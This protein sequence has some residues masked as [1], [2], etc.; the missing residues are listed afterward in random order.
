MTLTAETDQTRTDPTRT[1]HTMTQTHDRTHDVP[2]ATRPAAARPP[3]GLNL[4]YLRLELWRI[5]RDPVAMFFTAILP[6]F[7]Y[8][9]FGAA[10]GWSGEDAGNGNVAMYVMISMAAYGA[11]TATVGVGGFSAV[12]RMQGWG[13]Q[14][15]LTPMSDAQYVAIKAL[16]SLVI[17][18]VPITLIYALG[19]V[20]GAEAR[21][22]AWLGSAA[23]V[24]VGAVMF[25]LYGLIFGLAFRSESAVGAASGSLVILAFLGNIFYPL[26]GW[27]LTLA[28]FTPLYGYVQLA[29]FPLT[30]GESYD[31]EAGAMVHESLWVPV[32]NVVVWTVIFGALATWLVQR[33]RG[34]Q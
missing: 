30:E 25:S 26:S 24:V 13:R 11:V 17:A 12:E 15:G 6:A 28:K 19:T 22:S 16:V 3:R 2:G 29:R 27:L 10:S 32:T 21:L 9:I 14:L 4:T 1:E 33:S 23:I 7:F 20:T 8:L 34:R 18:L 5:A 31:M